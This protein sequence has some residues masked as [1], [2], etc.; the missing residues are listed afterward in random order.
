MNPRYAVA[1]ICLSILSAVWWQ[2]E[3]TSLLGEQALQAGFSCLVTAATGDCSKLWFVGLHQDNEIASLAFYGGIALALYGLVPRKQKPETAHPHDPLSVRVATEI[4]WRLIGVVLSALI[5]SVIIGIQFIPN[6]TG[7]YV[8]RSGPDAWRLTMKE[9]L[10]GNIS[11][12][13]ETLATDRTTGVLSD[14]VQP[15]EGRA[16][17]RNVE[18]T[19]KSNRLFGNSR[20]GSGSFDDK[21]IKLQFGRFREQLWRSDIQLFEKKKAE[22][23]ADALEMQARVAAFKQKQ[24]S[25]AARHELIAQLQKVDLKFRDELPNMD[26]FTTATAGKL[27]QRYKDISQKMDTVLNS[28]RLIAGIPAASFKRGQIV[29]ELNQG[30]FATQQNFQNVDLVHGQFNDHV[31]SLTQQGNEI[32]AKCQAFADSAGDAETACQ[33]FQKDFATYREKASAMNAALK[34]LDGIYAATKTHQDQIMA[35]A[36]SME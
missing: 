19:V 28:E 30:V 32:A 17:W 24:Q 18:L 35:E 14:D 6:S 9:S 27:E 16:S 33:A 34:K 3:L 31:G 2:N 12:E 4:N 7:T 8:E 23:Q 26:R 29:F 13:Y 15:V 20:T 36:T 21:S 5:V 22:I 1:G 25:D 11:G 10:S